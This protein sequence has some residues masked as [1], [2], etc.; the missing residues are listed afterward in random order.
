MG[1]AGLGWLRGSFLAE[2]G[3]ALKIEGGPGW[4][5]NRVTRADL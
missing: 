4:P 3:E 2:V 1:S 5:M